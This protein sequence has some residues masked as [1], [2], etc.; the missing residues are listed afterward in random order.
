MTAPTVQADP[1]RHTVSLPIPG[2]ALAELLIALAREVRAQSVVSVLLDDLATVDGEV[3]AEVCD[4]E[5]SYEA[6]VDRRDRAVRDLLDKLPEARLELPV[7]DVGPLVDQL[8][9]AGLEATGYVECEGPVCGTLVHPAD[10]RS[11]NGHLFCSADC[12]ADAQES[13]GA[14]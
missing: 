6:A 1:N 14:R 10:A 2:E 8:L 7:A 4:R 13:A 12:D 3:R 9:A 11:N 5:R